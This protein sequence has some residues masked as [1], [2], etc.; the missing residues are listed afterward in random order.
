VHGPAVLV[1]VFSEAEADQIRRLGGHPVI[2]AE[3][4]AEALLA[5]HD[6][7]SRQADRAGE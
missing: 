6:E 3:V 7:L 2:E 4:A 1:R 5:W